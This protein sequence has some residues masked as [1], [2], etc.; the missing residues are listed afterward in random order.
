MSNPVNLTAGPP[1]TV[2]DA[3]PAEA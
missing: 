3:E 1:E 2:L